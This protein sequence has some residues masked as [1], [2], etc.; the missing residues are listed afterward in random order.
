MVW[1]LHRPVWFHPCPPSQG[2]VPQAK[3]LSPQAKVVESRFGDRMQ[4]VC[5]VPPDSARRDL[6]PL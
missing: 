1:M 6:L 4:G 3:V 5:S 2:A